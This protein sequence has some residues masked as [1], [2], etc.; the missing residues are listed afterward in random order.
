[1]ST[2]LKLCELEV[3]Q[4]KKKKFGGELVQVPEPSQKAAHQNWLKLRHFRFNEHFTGQSHLF[5]TF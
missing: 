3:A 2:T 4:L 1:V 5:L